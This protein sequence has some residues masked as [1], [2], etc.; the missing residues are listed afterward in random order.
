[1]SNSAKTG[2]ETS[3]RNEAEM[4]ANSAESHGVGSRKAA[5]STGMEVQKTESEEAR[6]LTDSGNLPIQKT[7][8]EMQK[9]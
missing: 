3:E 8:N 4:H 7:I 5:N 2:K 9:E 6:S 1:M